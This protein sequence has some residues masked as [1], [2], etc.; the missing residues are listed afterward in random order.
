MKEKKLAVTA[1]IYNEHGEILAVSRKTD[2]NDF[3]LPGGKVDPGESM[4]ASLIREVKEE[5]GLDVTSC[6]AYFTRDD[7]DYV[8]TTFLC[9]YTGEINTTEAGLVKWTNFEEIKRGTFGAYNTMLEEHLKTN[10]KYIDGTYLV[11][12]DTREAFMIVRPVGWN[13]GNLQ[14]YYLVRTLFS[15]NRYHVVKS[16]VF[17]RRVD[18]VDMGTFLSTSNSLSPGEEYSFGTHLDVNQ[19]YEGFLYSYHTNG[20]RNIGLRYKHLIPAEDWTAVE[21]GLLCHDLIEDARETLND[22][23]DT[24]DEKSGE[25]VYALT[26][27]KGRNRAGRANSK[28]YDEMK[29][30]EHAEFA[31]LCDRIFN[32]ESGIRTGSTMLKKYRKEHDKFKEFLWTEKSI[33]LI[34]MWNDM[35]SA[36]FGKKELTR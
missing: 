8:S 31:K 35:E 16:S 7:G 18:I 27:E 30:V 19:Y 4:E 12:H 10:P 34:E 24:L 20:V 33:D 29:M 14:S 21:N 5:T 23:K 3:G 26:N 1:L 15:R 11:I 13:E 36:L 32:I 9:N 25:I 28:Y 2:Q 17:D 6:K 22:V